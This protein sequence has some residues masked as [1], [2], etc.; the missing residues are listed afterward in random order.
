MDN[1]DAP[2]PLG[3]LK[4]MIEINKYTFIVPCNK[5]QIRKPFRIHCDTF[6]ISKGG[7]SNKGKIPNSEDFFF[8]PGL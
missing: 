7:Q 1:I 8:G 3:M 2:Y 6:N 5:Y 4:L